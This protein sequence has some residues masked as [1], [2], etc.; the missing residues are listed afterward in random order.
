M[1]TLYIKKVAII[2]IL[3]ILMIALP[4]FVKATNEG[5]AVLNIEGDYLVYIDG[6][7]ATNFQFAFTDSNLTE[8]EAKANLTFIANWDDTNG[9]HVA[10][11]EKDTTFN[12]TKKLYVWILEGENATS[13]EL[14][15]TT[16]ITKA[17]M[18]NVEKLTKSIDVDT[19]Q[20]T[21]TVEEKDGVKT[22]TTVGKLVITDSNEFKYKYQLTKL[23]GNEKEEIKNITNLIDTLENSYSTMSMY[24]KV[25]VATQIKD[26][27]KNA[28]YQSVK[29]MTIE[30]P[31]EA[32]TGDKYLVLL[33]KVSGN[34]VE[35]FDAQ[36]MNCTRNYE[37][38]TI[39]EKNPVKTTHSLP[40]TYDSIV[41]IVILAVLAILVIA[42]LIRM[43]KL[44][45]KNEK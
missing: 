22:T 2:A 12:T 6:K 31:N 23:D 5:V 17:E 19:T 1:E 7:E 20:T 27:L 35:E 29:D 16:A 40:V 45:A 10:C 38:E 25:L 3:V 30:Q 32:Q 41:L 33:Q 43:R 44:N 36:F 42:I 13:Y 24:K 28:Q 9:V 37:S 21:T 15:L 14:D 26:A 4:T 11:L 39:K 18:E 8:T 34:N